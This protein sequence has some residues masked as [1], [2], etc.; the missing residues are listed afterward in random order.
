VTNTRTVTVQV[1]EDQPPVVE[2]GVD[3]LRKKGNEYLVTPIARVPFVP[4]SFVRDDRALSKV[5]FSTSYTQVDSKE[6]VALQAQVVA[7]Y[8]PMLRCLHHLR[9]HS[10][11]PVRPSLPIN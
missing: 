9:W 8:W 5:E 1:V 4:E 11:R 10:A 7:D 3:V 6:V 2:I